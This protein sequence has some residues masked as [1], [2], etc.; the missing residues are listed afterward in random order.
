MIALLQRS[1]K[2]RVTLFTLSIFVI[3]IW[4]LAFYASRV[5]RED[6]ERL[7]GEQQ[8]SI[9]SLLA[10]NI[11]QELGD[12]LS[13][14]EKV[15]ERLTPAMLGDAA[16]MQRFLED[17]PVL[18]TLFNGG[19]ITYGTD[20][21]VIADS[22]PAAG[23]IGANYLDIDTVAAALQEGRSTI[24]RLVMGKKL[25]APVFS[26]TVPVRDHQGKVIGA[27]GGVVNLGTPGFL[28]KITES[29]HG[30]TGGYLIVARDY[31]LIITATDKSRIMETLPPA[32]VNWLVD[33]FIQGYEGSGV[34]VNPR[35]VEVLSSAKGVPAAGW[36]LAAYMPTA[37]AFAPIRAM[38]ERMLLGTILFTLLAGSLTWWMLRR[39]L[40]PV[41][42]TAQTLAAQSAAGLPLQP[43]PI[44]RQDEVG[45]LF[46]GFNRLLLTLGQREEALKESEEN[47]AVT[48]H[49]IGDAVIATDTVGRVTRMN[50]MAERLCGWMLADALGRPLSEVFR[51]FNADTREPGVNPVQSVL[52]H[53]QVVGLA[54]HTVLLAKDGQEYRI[55]DSAA[56]IR[57]AAGEIVGVVLV[58]SDI[59]KKYRS[60]EALRD[61]E[62]RF[63]NLYEQAPLAY[64]SLDAAGNILQVNNAWLKLFGFTHDEAIGRF[65]GDFLDE[66]SLKTLGRE[67]PQFL[68]RGKVDGPVFDIRRKDG[69]TR[70]VEIN[71][72]IGYDSEGNFR[73]T[74]CIL[75]DIT[76]RKKAEAALLESEERWKFALEGAGEGVW[77]W[78]IQTGDALY[79]RRWKEM[80]G[81]AENEIG[82]NSS[83]WSS[84]VHPE[85]MPK[86]MVAIQA[87]IDGKTRSAAIE[88]RMLCKDGTW[89]WT[90]GRGMVV[91][92]NA[93]GKPLRLVGTNADISE[94]KAT[95]DKIERLAFYD[96]LTDLP[97]RRL[98]LDRLEQALASSTRHNRHGA[99]MLLD[100][101][102][103]KTL[104]DTLG[105]DV[106]DQFLV[107]VA[108]RL[109]AAVREGDTVARHGGDEFVVILE[110]LS[111]DALAVTQAESVAVKILHVVSQPYLLDLTLRADLKNTLS[112]HCTSS[113][114]ITL[115]RGHSLSADELMRRADTAM[116]QAKAGGRNSLRFFD[117][118]MQAVVAARATLDS[119]LR[120]AVREGQFCLCYQ[121]QV[122]SAGNRTGAEV[123]VRWQ[124]PRRG[125]VPPV[126]FIPQAEATGLIIPLGHW[127]LETAC[128][129]L[130]AWEALPKMC[131][132][133][134]AVNVSA[135]QFRHGDFV[136]QVLAMIDSTGVNPQKLKLELTESLLLDDVEDTISK[137]TVLKARGVGFSLD[138]F[139]TGYSSLSYL[140]R[141]PLD[142]LKIDQSFV[143]DVLT[144][145]ND[146]AIAR[147]I[148]ALA[149]S[150]GLA[151]IAEGVETEA[152]R[153]FLAANGCT[154]YQGFLFGR[155]MP[156]EEFSHPTGVTTR[157]V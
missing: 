51:L 33:R 32:G 136:D 97:N 123:L 82:N 121:P 2:T 90:L 61:S 3:S 85:D 7:L 60:E 112:Y 129:Q 132:L 39:Q 144:D 137:M 54:N 34:V 88:F 134:V 40:A 140:K 22:L 151:V 83:E 148:V 122:D 91:S 67:F 145:P 68:S 117:P 25:R 37:E 71:G 78:N 80:L 111:E 53:G 45:E 30:T 153:E 107:E 26:I 24:G 35:G 81:F 149:Q 126:E 12:R 76:E 146:A 109:Q 79:S 38:Q 128:A 110:D 28:D 43:L 75:T 147:T 155:P 102:D 130:V 66:C 89:L 27:L 104:N 18:Q 133:T 106:G 142:Q 48:L 6:M 17:R 41:V 87:H 139:G 59:T 5:L 20:G 16:T 57:N 92:R 13:A 47:L 114:G 52:A 100:M 113:I 19:I 125:I 115:F 36:Y 95:A 99:L 15:V 50:P 124:H 14:L 157:E 141:L 143:R 62:E 138:D 11:N 72:R 118:E 94:R 120:E 103:F 135:R 49:S 84:R 46:G 119:D 77:D 29:T 42:A 93:N 116:Y 64:Q 9:V 156:Q 23:R 73:Q 44:T 63:R 69:S 55:A 70:L 21:T 108:S 8:Y 98:L 154:A 1:L 10:A 31:R 74:H 4:A 127:V 105:H 86:V 150:M 58:F 152:Q 96:P 101:D 65:I 131:H 56:P